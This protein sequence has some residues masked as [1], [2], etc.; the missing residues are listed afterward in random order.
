MSSLNSSNNDDFQS[1]CSDDD[2]FSSIPSLNDIL[3][4]Q[5]SDKTRNFNAVHINAQSIPAHFTD[6]LAT[7]NCMN[8]HAILVS[9]SWLKP[10]LSSTS[11]ILPGY[12][13]IRNDRVGS[14]G[15]GVAIYLRDHVPFK[16]INLSTQPPPPDAGEHIF[17]E[18]EMQHTKVLVGVYYCPSSSINFFP[19]FEN[20]LENLV[21]TYA[22]TI[23]MGDFNTCLLKDDNRSISFK[24]TSESCNLSVLPLCA[25]HHSPNSNPTLLDLMLVSCP[26]LVSNHGQYSADA[27]SYHDLIFL[28]YQVRPPKVKSKI[29]LQRNFGGM[30]VDI[31]R[32]DALNIDWGSI[33]NSQFVDQKITLFNSALTGL[34]DKHAPIRAIKIKHPPAP[35]LTDEIKIVLTKKACAKSRYKCRPSDHNWEKYVSI[36]NHCN[37][38]VRDAQ[39]RHI[40]DSIE[41][42]EPAKIWKFLKSLGVGKSQNNSHSSDLDVNLL[43]NHFITSSNI[44]QTSK[45][46]TL[47]YLSSLPTPDYTPFVFT[48]FSDCDVEKSIVSIT[49]KAIGSDSV[50]RNMIIPILDIILPIISHILNFSISSRTFPSSWKKALITPIPKKA[51]PSSFSEYRP[52]SILPFLSKVL[53]RLVHKQL[54]IFLNKNCLLNPHQSG[55]RP[56]HSTVTALVKITEDI[57]LAMDDGKVTILT[58]LDFS[59]AFNTVDYDILLGV[60][61]SLNISPTVIEWFRSYLYGRRQRIRIDDF[62]YHLY[63]DDLQIYTHTS[64]EG[65]V[66]AIDTTNTNLSSI[67]DWSRSYGLT[68]NPKKTQAIIVGSSRMMLNNILTLL[69]DT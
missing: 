28:S 44:D 10:V 19:S 27:F 57:R 61:C 34:Y 3:T 31:L 26:D 67:A 69:I 68:V 20:L 23:I 35:W 41:N 46:N 12:R 24:S 52:I 43:N 36:R 15:G 48:Q 13:L 25:T 6:M 17:I 14:R 9:E 21:P 33:V 8:I 29:L 51:N 7:F 47:A 1:A 32:M 55:F 16:I 4:A 53:E 50:S 37:K 58:L 39:R 11:Y 22:H 65:L 64:I 42:G 62:S 54:S 30:N 59:N 45:D 5:F 2:S 66:S 38:V 56:G 60:L 49:S 40:H 63:A 18:V